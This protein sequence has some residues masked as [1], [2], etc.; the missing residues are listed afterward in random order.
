MTH[1]ILLTRLQGEKILLTNGGVPKDPYR[2]R[3][4]PAEEGRMT[5]TLPPF[6]RPGSL[7]S[8]T[9]CWMLCD[10]SD[11]HR[12]WFWPS[13]DAENTK[14]DH[15]EKSLHRHTIPCFASSKSPFGLQLGSRETPHASRHE[16]EEESCLRRNQRRAARAVWVRC[17]PSTP[18]RDPK[19]GGLARSSRRRSQPFL[20]SYCRSEGNQACLPS[21]P[22]SSSREGIMHS[23]QVARW[24]RTR[25][26]SRSSIL[27]PNSSES[28][29]PPPSS[30]AARWE[31]Q[32]RNPPLIHD[33]VP[34]EAMKQT[35]LRPKA[36][37]DLQP[38]GLSWGEEKSD[39]PFVSTLSPPSRLGP[40]MPVFQQASGSPDQAYLDPRC[41]YVGYWPAYGPSAL[42]LPRAIWREIVAVSTDV[43]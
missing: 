18:R 32:K 36:Y 37:V 5:P 6:L 41:V 30:R 17:E 19:T 42:H 1:N 25:N 22:W 12:I 27:T 14:P 33:T 20:P 9:F 31:D 43:P 26:C 13:A 16:T 3:H 40:D 2:R 23:E 35:V 34:S 39:S 4:G 15:D 7:H 28:G 10:P 24:A 21:P 8:P 29:S 38:L 11:F